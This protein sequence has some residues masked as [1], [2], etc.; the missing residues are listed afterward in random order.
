MVKK[1]PLV[2]SQE[3]LACLLCCH[4]SLGSTFWVLGLVSPFSMCSNERTLWLALMVLPGFPHVA[5]VTLYTVP[6]E[7]LS[8]NDCHCPWPPL[9]LCPKGPPHTA[10]EDCE[11]K[12][13]CHQPIHQE[14][15]W[16]ASRN[17]P[18]GGRSPLGLRPLRGLHPLCTVPMVLWV[19]LCCHVS[20]AGVD[21]C[22]GLVGLQP[23]LIEFTYP[24][25]F[26]YGGA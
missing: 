21:P 25:V 13:H 4:D 2:G 20:Q 15:W 19:G 9:R 23:L 11:V 24:S 16:G 14:E 12:S 1:E 6:R 3:S 8:T 10:R 17:P 22:G 5:L 7:V 26:C 18:P